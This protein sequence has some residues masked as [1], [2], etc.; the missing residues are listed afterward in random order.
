[1]FHKQLIRNVQTWRHLSIIPNEYLILI[2]A[3]LNW[4]V[5]SRL[6]L[7]LLLPKPNRD[8]EKNGLPCSPKK[9]HFYWDYKIIPYQLFRLYCHQVY[10]LQIQF[11]QTD[12][13]M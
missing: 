12:H 8:N 4:N 13:C 1:M 9:F 2:Y 11:S 10:L 6:H 3:N 7:Q 5:G